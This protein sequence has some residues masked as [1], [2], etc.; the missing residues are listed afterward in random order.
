MS[1]ADG[2]FFGTIPEKLTLE[3]LKSKGIYWIRW[4]DAEG[5]QRA[6]ARMPEYKRCFWQCPV[7]GTLADIYFPDQKLVV[8]VDGCYWHC[9]DCLPGNKNPKLWQ[10]EQGKRDSK[11][12]KQLMNAGYAV[13]RIWECEVKRGEFAKVDVALGKEK[14]WLIKKVTDT[15]IG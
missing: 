3:Y 4:D 5:C 1:S 2:K 15:V 12:M 8:E 10:L 14:L 13:A 11:N 6:F 7:A 9:H